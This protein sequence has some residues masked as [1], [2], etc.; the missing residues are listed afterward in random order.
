MSEAAQPTPSAQT[1]AGWAAASGELLAITDDAGEL[2]WCNEAFRQR[3]GAALPAPLKLAPPMHSGERIAIGER[4]FAVHVQPVAQGLAWQLVDETAQ[5][6]AERLRELLEVAQQFGRLGLWERD[7]TTGRGHWDHHVFAFWGLDPAQGTP[8]FEEAT[9]YIHPEDHFTGTYLRSLDAP[10]R[11]SQHYRVLR[12]DGAVRHIHSQWEVKAGSDGRLARIVGVMMDDTEVYELARSLGDASAQLQLAV[13]LADITIWRH[14][15]RSGRMHYNE[16]GYATLGIPPRPEGLPIEE[17]RGY[18]HPDDLPEVLASAERALTSE[19]PTDMQARYRRSDGSWRHVLT[20]RVVQRAA[21]GTPL[22]FLG[23]G[24]D[25][26]EQVE[27]RRQSAELERRLE[28]AAEA[29]QIGIWWRDPLAGKGQ[30]NAQM[31]AMTGRDPSLGTPSLHEWE[32]T[33][34]HPEDR[35]RMRL[36]P[37]MMRPDKL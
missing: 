26:T 13:E 16:R 19:R 35:E 17:V 8:D 32:T 29:A 1:L 23:V 14:D 36:A 25:L 31:F 21:D 15:L 37:R 4:W 33:I 2:R 10:G 12:P 30:W 7:F 11:Y 34:L 24:L 20:R 22:A 5:R 27:Q 28:L 18:I 9:R 6:E 3:F